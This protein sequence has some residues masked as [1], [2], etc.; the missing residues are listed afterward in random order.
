[1]L[2][3]VIHMKFKARSTAKVVT[4]EIDRNKLKSP[5]HSRFLA[6]TS[7]HRN[8]FIT[9]MSDDSGKIFAEQQLI[10]FNLIA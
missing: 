9:A 4:V 8:G 6:D 7:G 2:R 1:M 10:P 3:F 5:R